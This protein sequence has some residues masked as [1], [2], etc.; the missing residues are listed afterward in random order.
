MSW[1]DRRNLKN[2]SPQPPCERVPQ[3]AWHLDVVFLSSCF[4]ITDG[5][6]DMQDGHV[7]SCVAVFSQLHPLCKLADWKL[8]GID[9]TETWVG[10]KKK[11][12]VWKFYRKFAFKSPNLI[13]SSTSIVSKTTR[14]VIWVN[15]YKIKWELYFLKEYILKKSKAQHFVWTKHNKLLL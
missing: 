13:F 14:Y 8:I 15:V 3:S 2:Y 1:S 12:S 11:K 5:S 6:L 7:W 10:E 4:L 9:Y